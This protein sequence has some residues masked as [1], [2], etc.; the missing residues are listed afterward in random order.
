[1]H[2]TSPDPLNEILKEALIKHDFG[3]GLIMLE[4]I[5]KHAATY[6]HFLPVLRYALSNEGFATQILRDHEVFFS[7]AQIL[8]F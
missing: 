5:Y 2:N 8:Y 6:R 7:V 1:M 4:K 3:Q